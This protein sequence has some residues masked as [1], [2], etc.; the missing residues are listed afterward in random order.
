MWAVEKDPALRSDFTNITILERA[1]DAAR[2]R[3]KVEQAIEAIPRL[4]RAGR[5]AAVPARHAR[6]APDPTSTSTT[7]SARSPSRRPAGMR[8]AARPRGGGRGDA[9]RP[10]ASAVGVHPRRG[11]GGRTGCA[12][13]EGAPH[14]HRRR[15]R[16]EAVAQPARLRARPAGAA[17]AFADAAHRRRGRS[18]SDCAAA[19]ADPVNRIYA[20][21]PCSSEAVDVHVAPA[22]RR[23]PGAASSPPRT[24]WPARSRRAAGVDDAVRLAGSVRRQLLVTEPSLARTCCGRVRWP[25]GSSAFQV[26]LD[27]IEGGGGD[28]GRQRERRVRHRHHRRARPVPRAHGRP[29]RRVAH[30]DADQHAHRQR[31][32]ERATASPR[33]G[34]SCR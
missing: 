7:T 13:P 26:P 30:G 32:G 14:D 1:P 12:P 2:V 20:A 4:R 29:V 3:A 28:A 11:A 15:R 24:S 31:R 8:R 21:R 17:G 19:F 25:C 5:V 33:R 27:A 10:V 9:A 16:R 34:C 23:A 22:V 6:V 18:R